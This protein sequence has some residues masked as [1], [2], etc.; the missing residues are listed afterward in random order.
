MIKTPALIVAVYVYVTTRLAGSETL[1][2]KYQQ[3]RNSALAILEELADIEAEMKN[4]ESA[5]VDH[6]MRIIRD[7]RWTDMDWFDNVPAGIDLDGSDGLEDAAED[8]IGPNGNGEGLLLPVKQGDVCMSEASDQHYLQAGLGT[9]VQPLLIFFVLSAN[10]QE[11]AESS[12]LLERR[13][14]TRIQGMEEEH[15]ARD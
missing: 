5:D 14:K 15:S 12:G 1:A 8:E 6:C 11:D 10:E 4:G 13:S 2:M 9:M 7:K 3:Q